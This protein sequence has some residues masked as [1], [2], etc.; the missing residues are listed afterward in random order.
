MN[1]IFTIIL[2]SLATFGSKAQHFNHFAD[3]IRITSKIPELC[4]A[5]VSSDSVFEIHALGYKKINTD[6]LASL[7]DRFRIGSNTKAITGFIAA[8]LV[9]QGKLSWNTKFF[10]LCP[11]LKQ[12][13]RKEYH[14]LT[15][16][17]L[18]SF[19][20]KL[21]PYTYTY[22]APRKEQFTGNDSM[23]RYEFAQ[24][25]FKQAPVKQKDSICFS[26]LG[27]VAAGLMLEKVSGKSYENLVNDLGKRL[28][29]SFDFGQPNMRD[30]MQVWGH[31]AS[32]QPEA[33]ADN[34]KL[35]WLLAAGNINITLPDYLKFIQLQLRGLKGNSGLLD[36][37]EFQFLH[38]GLK[39]FAIGWFWDLDE[40]NQA[41][42]YNTGNPGTFLSKV[43]IYPGRDRAY[44]ILTNVQ[45]DLAEEGMDLLADELKSRN[46]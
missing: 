19:R 12:D 31:N 22:A 18:L 10:T 26:N 46:K 30:T 34:Y 17:Q 14:E 23:Q 15:L 24:W 9:K 11:E 16:L 3:S 29:I 2:A 25:F 21:F 4:Y 43:Y 35:N 5:V 8:E 33:P 45:S 20:T 6:R 32:L 38:Y 37:N 27:Y 39:Q 1:K 36:K 40:N 7:N 42:S 28:G 44:I 41:Y 13:S